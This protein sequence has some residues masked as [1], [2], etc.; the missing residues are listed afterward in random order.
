[1]ETRNKK[2]TL[3]LALVICFVPGVF[4]C[5]MAPVEH[6]AK[7]RS[8]IMQI[9]LVINNTL[10]G[11][12]GSGFLVEG[13]LVTNSHVLSGVTSNQIAI[14]FAG[15]D[16][17]DP[18][19]YILIT[20]FRKRIVRESLKSEED[21]VYLKFDNPRLKNRHVFQFTDSSKLSVGEQVV[22]LG[23]PFRNPHM[24]SHIG[25]V[26]AVYDANN[27]KTIQIDGSVNG[28]N[29]GG[30]L[31]D[32]KT[33][34]VA[35][36]ITKANVG[37]LVEEFD[38]LIEAL[39]QNQKLFEDREDMVALGGV[40]LMKAFKASHAA[41]EQIAKNLKQSANV[42]IGYAYSSN[43]VRDAIASA[44]KQK[45]KSHKATNLQT[46]LDLFSPDFNILDLPSDLFLPDLAEEK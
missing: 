25:Y 35:G 7:V 46:P 1:M 26:S 36:I 45:N 11:S 12:L 8:G 29:S 22:F 44:K 41:M 21:Y 31:L 4:S 14:R 38:N 2:T 9:S 20:N 30:P 16:P 15:S 27:I 3:L 40:D 24:T 18:D 13:G 42:G 39:Q 33:G 10:H 32:L 5:A 43:Y 19:S 37:F 6:I 17:K 34:K 28:G 23:F